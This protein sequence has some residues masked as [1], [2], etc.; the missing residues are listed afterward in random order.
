[1]SEFVTFP[2]SPSYEVS[3]DGRVRRIGKAACMS[4]SPD[5]DGYP[6]MTLSEAG[7]RSTWKVSLLVCYTFHGPR[8]T[9]RHQAAH[10]DGDKT[11]SHEKNIRWATPKEN[12]A[13]KIAHGKANHGERHGNAKLTNLQ[14]TE[15][16]GRAAVLPR[17]TSGR[18]VRRGEFS[19]L[20]RFYGITVE[21]TRAII[22][23][24]ARIL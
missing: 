23:R 4:Q 22:N 16:R 13:D 6:K 17:S 7:K 12:E 18:Q 15:L 19:R 1:M 14:V 5:G 9:P 21:H 24:Q 3:R 8:P 2:L 20:A 10:R 11:N